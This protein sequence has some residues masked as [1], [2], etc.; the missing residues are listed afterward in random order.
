[1]QAGGARLAAGCP[2]AAGGEKWLKGT[3]TDSK[4]D[5]LNTAPKARRW[6]E[7]SL[8]DNTVRKHNHRIA[9]QSLSK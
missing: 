1:M 9:K 3:L 4:E 6:T 7:W 8:S 2:G 5:V